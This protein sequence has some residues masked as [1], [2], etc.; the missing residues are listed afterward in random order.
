MADIEYSQTPT[1]YQ[2]ETRGGMGFTPLGG[3]HD[4]WGSFFS[5]L[6]RRR[7]AEREREL[8]EERRRW[9]LEFGLKQRAFEQAEED[10][11]R[12]LEALN[13]PRPLPRGDF[14]G[15]TGPGSGTDVMAINLQSGGLAPR[16]LMTG[17]GEVPTA[18]PLHYQL[19]GIKPQM[20]AA[21]RPAQADPGSRRSYPGA[22][23]SEGQDD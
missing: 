2:L 23:L 1:Q 17:Y 22:G 16:T 9:D 7:A 8:A 21:F 4:G 20:A 14:K 10:R 6:A 3:G 13:A 5:A 15:W 18:T 19:M 12:G 11:L